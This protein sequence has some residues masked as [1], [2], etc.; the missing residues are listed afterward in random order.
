MARSA[1]DAAILLQAMAG[2]DE[3]DSTSIN[4]PVPDYSLHLTESLQGLKIGLPKEFFQHGLNSQIAQ[5]ID[6]ALNEYRKLGAT[7]IE[8]SMPTLTMAIPAYYVIASAEC[9]SNLSRYDGVRFGHR[10]EHPADLTDL[11]LRSRAEGFGTEVKRRI[12]M[13][14][15]ALSAGYYDAY[16]L[17]AQ[18]I[19][20][21]ISD[22]FQHAL[23]QVD[24]I[25]S[26]VTPSH[27]FTLGEKTADPVHM[28]LEDLYTIAINL[29]GLPA[30]SIPIGLSADTPEAP[31]LPVGLQLIGAYFSEAKLLN[32]AHA[33][34]QVTN[35]HQ[36]IP[37]GF[38]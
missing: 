13:G 27:A 22:D 24:V 3:K 2:F 23:T 15:Y 37:T 19:R 21:L 17:K 38:E 7:I 28:Y 34:Q 8:L 10:C 30:M 18:K 5:D 14:T 33:Y 12:L 36:L 32:I 25:M 31:K 9:S 1:E 26:P 6:N 29:A 11:Y 20:R 4:A 35:W 16:Y